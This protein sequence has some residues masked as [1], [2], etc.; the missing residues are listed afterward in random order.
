MTAGGWPYTKTLRVSGVEFNR[1]TILCDTRI[2]V[3]DGTE[4]HVL[5]DEEDRSHVLLWR[6]LL[7]L[8]SRD[9]EFRRVGH[10]AI[11]RDQ[12]EAVGRTIVYAIV[13]ANDGPAR[14]AGLADLHLQA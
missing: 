7:P 13:V 2:S 1:E 6:Q 8:L 3:S 9:P 4:S 14:M 10:S 5:R 11:L 12:D